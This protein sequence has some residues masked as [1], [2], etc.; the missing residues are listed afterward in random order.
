VRRHDK[1]TEHLDAAA[2]M[3]R[4]MAM[5]F[6]LDKLEADRAELR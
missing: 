5:R 4:E 6:W 3:F 1:A 2:E